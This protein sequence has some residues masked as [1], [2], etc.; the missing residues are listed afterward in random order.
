MS[1]RLKHARH[2]AGVLFSLLFFSACSHILPRTALPTDLPERV[3]LSDTP[4]FAQE[5]YQCGPAALAMVLGQRGV[6]VSPDELVAK[7]YLPK[8]QGSVAPEMMAT[9]RGYGLVVYELPPTLDALLREVA[10]GNPVLVLQNLGLAWLPKWHYAVVVGY[11][12][13]SQQ[14]ILRSGTTERHRPSLALFDRTWQRGNRWGVTL[15]RPGH[16]PASD[17]PFNYFRAAYALEQTQQ[18]E[19][20]MVAYRGGSERWPDSLPLWLAQANLAYRTGDYSEAEETLRRALKHQPAAAPLWN[21]LA[22]ALAAQG[23][24]ESALAAASCAVDRARGEE[25]YAQSQR[26]IAVM[27]S[28]LEATCRPLNC[29]DVSAVTLSP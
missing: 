20:A 11:D 23:C 25:A 27:P 7:V 13:G 9:A 19:A 4:F 14:V 16:L 8:R 6:V 26:E 17:A 3:E 24:R 10:A 28:R 12:L 22:Y 1:R 18:L 29:P 21:N 5:R 15:L 2:L